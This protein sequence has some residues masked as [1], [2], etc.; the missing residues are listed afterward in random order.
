MR[1]GA[2]AS[3]TFAGFE[4]GG[5]SSEFTDSVDIWFIYCEWP[6]HVGWDLGWYPWHASLH[7]VEYYCVLGLEMD[8]GSVYC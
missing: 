2:E 7:Y 6:V 4:V 8:S 1:L 5:L 3:W